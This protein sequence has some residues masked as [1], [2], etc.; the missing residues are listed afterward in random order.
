M[1]KLSGVPQTT[2]ALKR[3]KRTKMR[4]EMQQLEERR[5]LSV[6]PHSTVMTAR[7]AGPAGKSA[8][9]VAGS[10]VTAPAAHRGV[11]EAGHFLT[12][13]NQVAARSLEP[14]AEKVPLT[15]SLASSLPRA[16]LKSHRVSQRQVSFEIS[17]RPGTTVSIVD[18]TIGSTPEIGT[19]DTSGIVQTTENL[20]LGKNVIVVKAMNSFGQ[21]TTASMVVDRVLT[22]VLILPGY[23]GSE[24]SS[25][26]ALAF[27]FK[28]G[29]PA[30]KLNASPI[31][32]NLATSLEARGYKLG[33]DLFVL[34]Y[35]WR[36]PAAPADSSG[37]GILSGVTAQ[38]ITTGKIT[39]QV[40]YLGRKLA[41]IVKD[42]PIDTQ[43][44]IV[45]HSNGNIVARS[46]VQSD[47]YGASF[48][49][50][51][52]TMHLPTVNDFVMVAGPNLGASS[53][54]NTWNNNLYGL[55]QG[56]SAARPAQKRAGRHL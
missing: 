2:A 22:P 23:L 3:I 54:W 48:V 53:A 44:D 4:P 31:Y 40:D 5:L 36:L 12:A 18:R 52:Q 34:P 46:Y 28:R 35:D 7:P 49:D 19:V 25:T 9:E 47:A 55:T 41:Q 29:F 20:A 37:D 10:A 32:H 39:Y 45:A 43:V 17:S 38:Q 30:D 11:T 51:G 21:Q 33:T 42:H 14:V 1:G 16:S 26:N 50:A 24:P 56:A 6:L 27:G 13:Q 15:I 8:A